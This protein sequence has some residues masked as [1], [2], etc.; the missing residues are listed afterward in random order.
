MLLGKGRKRVERKGLERGLDWVLW[1]C[2]ERERVVL[3]WVKD[4][5]GNIG[6]V[7]RGG[8]WE[9]RDIL[10]DRENGESMRV[11]DIDRKRVNE[12]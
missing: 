9:V 10:D 8:R 5:E 2:L 1:E 11:E 3:E 12:R 7:R 4:Y 6:V